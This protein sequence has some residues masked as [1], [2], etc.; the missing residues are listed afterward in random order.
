VTVG[1]VGVLLGT[2][3]YALPPIINFLPYYGI[4][5][6]LTSY[7]ISSDLDTSVHPPVRLSS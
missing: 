2:G 4:A 6:V 5:T 1:G 3:R 7:A